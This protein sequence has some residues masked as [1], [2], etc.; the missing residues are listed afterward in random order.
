MHRLVA[1]FVQQ[2][3]EDE[4][5]RDAVE[6]TMLTTARRL[7]NDGDP[8]P[9]LALQPHLRHITDEAEGRGDER[10]A[11]LCSSL[12]YH[13]G[14]IGDYQAA[15]P[16]FERVLD[17]G[18]APPVAYVAYLLPTRCLRCLPVAHL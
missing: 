18:E 14:A 12:D 9:L 3:A 8:R 16:Y 1:R 13:L 5:A 4:T 17:D 10:A 11:S 15:R 7:N 6:Q 2:V